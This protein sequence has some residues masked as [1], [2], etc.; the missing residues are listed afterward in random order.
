MKTVPDK[1]TRDRL[2]ARMKTLDE[3]STPLWG[4]MNVYQMLKHCTVSEQMYLDKKQYKRVFPG[5]LIGK[6]TLNNFLKDE[7]PMPR[8]A[9]T[10]ADFIITETTGNVLAERGKW[11]ALIDEYAAFNH[12]IIHG[13]SEK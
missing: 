3:N 8:N 5:R 10:S 13:S 11:I 1:T 4:K 12:E 7:A 9:P 2:V 6:R